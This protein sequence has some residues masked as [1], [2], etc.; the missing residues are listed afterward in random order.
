MGVKEIRMIGCIM[1]VCMFWR[2]IVYNKFNSLYN[3][4]IGL[5]IIIVIDIVRYFLKNLLDN[6]YYQDG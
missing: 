5:Q 3:Q 4:N 2:L 6:M 1:Y